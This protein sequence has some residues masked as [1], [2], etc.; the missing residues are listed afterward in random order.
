MVI[1]LDDSDDLMK[2][3]YSKN[4]NKTDFNFNHSPNTDGFYGAV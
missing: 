1:I 2:R 4:R 3:K